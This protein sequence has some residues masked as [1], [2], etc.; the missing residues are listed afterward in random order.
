MSTSDQGKWSLAA[1]CKQATRVLGSNS[2]FINRTMRVP[3]I[4]DEVLS[5]LIHIKHLA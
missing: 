5:E 3:V 4:V 1:K 2:S